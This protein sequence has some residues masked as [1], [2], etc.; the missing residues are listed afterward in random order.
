MI[1]PNLD[2][3]ASKS[4]NFKNCYANGPRTAHGL[5]SILC[6]WP[7]IPGY[8]LIRQSKY[9]QIG[10]TT[11]SSIFKGMGYETGFIYGGNS[12]F[13]E[14]KNFVQAN[15]FDKIYDNYVLHLRVP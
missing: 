8:P 6:S 4:I 13:D 3:L 9:Q 2:Y 14:M 10:N 7:T 11:F 15:S 1:T 12:E 5:S